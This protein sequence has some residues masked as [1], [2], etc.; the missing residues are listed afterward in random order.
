M[1]FYVLVA[2]VVLRAFVLVAAAVLLIH[3]VSACPACFAPSVPVRKQWF[4]VLAP[5]FEWRW[6][7]HC[8][9]QGPARRVGLRRAPAP[10]AP[11]PGT[12]PPPPH[13]RL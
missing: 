11:P 12:S 1:V 4:R 9:W 6:C 5:R 10:F 7:P 8:G 13:L 2:L 3:P